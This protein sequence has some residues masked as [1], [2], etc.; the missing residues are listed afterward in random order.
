MTDRTEHNA[1]VVAYGSVATA[2]DAAVEVVFPE[3]VAIEGA[4]ACSNGTDNVVALQLGID[5]LTIT[6]TPA[7]TVGDTASTFDIIAWGY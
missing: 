2:A 4:I 3:F 6:I 1:Q 5:G 7:S